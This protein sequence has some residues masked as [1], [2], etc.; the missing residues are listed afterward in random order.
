MDAK[1]EER[2]FGAWP[3]RDLPQHEFLIPDL[4]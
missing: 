2:Q 4:P 1:S 3:K